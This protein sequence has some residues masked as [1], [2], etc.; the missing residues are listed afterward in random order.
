MGN[1]SSMVTVMVIRT[2]VDK[3]IMVVVEDVIILGAE[4]YFGPHDGKI[5]VY[6]QKQ[7]NHNDGLDKKIDICH[8]CRLEGHWSKI[9]KS[10][11]HFVHLYQDS[12]KDKKGRCVETN[13][14]DNFTESDFADDTNIIQNTHLDVADFLID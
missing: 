1:E 3:V 10:P 14:A 13:F 2:M 9:C 7:Q 4:I 12:L 5:N 6:Q 11:K 8:R